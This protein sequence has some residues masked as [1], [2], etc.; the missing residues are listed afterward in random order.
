MTGLLTLIRSAAG[1]SDDGRVSL[2]RLDMGSVQVTL[3]SVELECRGHRRVLCPAA[4]I[5]VIGTVSRSYLASKQMKLETDLVDQQERTQGLP[6]EFL[7]EHECGDWGD[8]GPIL[9]LGEGRA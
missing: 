4:S 1:H 5:L 6:D 2:K 3:T 9:L 8:R 7:A